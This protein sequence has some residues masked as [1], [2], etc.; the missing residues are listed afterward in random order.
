MPSLAPRDDFPHLAEVV[1]LNSGSIGLMPL[2]VQEAAAAF[3][4]DIWLR[5]T[6]GFDE[7]AETDC[8]EEA[9][10]AA[11]ALLRAGRDDV[12][13]VK[14]ATEAFAMLAWW[15]RPP[16][17]SNVVTIDIEHPSTA[18]PWLRVARETGAEQRLVRVWD[19]PGS[20]SLARVAELVDERTAVIAVSYVQYSTGYRFVLS[21]LAE[22]AHAHG[23]LLAVDATQAAGMAPVD[24]ARDDID[25][26]VA[27]GYKWLC[28]PFGAAVCWLRPELRERFDPPFVGWRSTEDPYT[29]DARTMPLAR[30]ARSME[31]STMG[32]GS[33]VAL[34]RALR[35]VLDLGVERVLAHDLA[36]AARLADG[37]ERLGATVLTPRDD[38]HRGGIVTARYPGRDGEEV[39]ARLNDAGVIVSPRF[40]ATRFSL[41]FFNDETDVDRAL[42]T[43]ERIL[44]SPA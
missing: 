16:A 8:L 1:Y 21:E 29:F 27:G 19:D 11:A 34:G 23:A 35:Y 20:L 6:T 4:R 5:G 22:L 42:G 7:A 24:V 37:L 44:A 12:A 26:L 18:Y 30:T 33:A 28:G 36:L 2:P 3:E 43:L 32:Y 13:I 15:V 14:S 9:R 40:G 17:G 10:D 38:A 31:Y 25:L 41:H 39:A